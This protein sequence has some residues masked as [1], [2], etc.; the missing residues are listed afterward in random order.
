MGNTLSIAQR[1]PVVYTLSLNALVFIL[2]QFLSEEVALRH[3]AVSRESVEAGRY[4][5]LLTACF[6][7][8]SLPHLINNMSALY[9]F[10]RKLSNEFGMLQFLLL[11]IFSGILS[12]YV[13]L[14]L[15]KSQGF[16]LGASGSVSAVTGAVAVLFPSWMI[17]ISD[18]PI[19]ASLYALVY[20]LGEFFQ[21]RV[22]AGKSDV[23]HTAHWYNMFS[24]FTVFSN[25]L[26]SY[27][28]SFR[29]GSFFHLFCFVWL[30]SVF[31]FVSLFGCLLV[32]L[33]RSHLPFPPLGVDRSWVFFS[34]S[35]PCFSPKSIE[36]Q[37]HGPISNV[38][39][40]SGWHH[41]LLLFIYSFSSLLQLD[42]QSVRRR[43]IF[44]SLLSQFRNESSVRSG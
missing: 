37:S 14:F 26:Q 3:L 6:S 39:F 18:F 4:Y 9:F 2:N 21:A 19:P 23:A 43:H 42:F 13:W 10:G 11:Y 25:L 24:F 31:V 30:L 22:T 16:C 12:N 36:Q 40:L 32:C 38:F 5:T 41:S 27:C 15:D 8:F 20:L 29:G 34:D 35:P 1:D 44:L 7:H 33:I 28:M 17:S